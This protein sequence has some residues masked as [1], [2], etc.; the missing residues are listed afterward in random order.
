MSTRTR[1]H[2]AVLLVWLLVLTGS[3]AADAGTCRNDDAAPAA[4]TMADHAGH[5]MHVTDGD[6]PDGAQTGD[7]Q[8]GCPCAGACGQGCQSPTPIVAV[9][10]LITLCATALPAVA[11]SSALHTATHP[12]LRP[13]A[14]SI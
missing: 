4:S 13:P 12:P 10:K 1:R 3:A 8:C 6:A 9:Q 5:V 14:A 11:R 2:V 7:C